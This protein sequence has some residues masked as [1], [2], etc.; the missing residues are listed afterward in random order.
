M[1]KCSIAS[2]RKE[3]KNLEREELVLVCL[4]LARYKKDN[5][6][7]VSFLVF[8]RNEEEFILEVKTEIHF[9]FTGLKLLSAFQQKKILQKSIR[10][11][12]KYSKF[13]LSKTFDL[14]MFMFICQSLRDSGISLYSHT[15]AGTIY[16]KILLKASKI[17]ST[18]HEE[19][20]GDFNEDL[21]HLAI[22]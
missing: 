7:L 3:L 5:K 21:L 14:V 11:I 17:H 20:Q 18:L 1:D 6:E 2:I 9:E 19:I 22:N 10:K 4:R 8:Q 15:F 13:C 16:K 12:N